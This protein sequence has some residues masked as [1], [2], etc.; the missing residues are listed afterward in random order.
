MEQDGKRWNKEYAKCIA[1]WLAWGNERKTSHQCAGNTPWKLLKIAHPNSISDYIPTITARSR[2]TIGQRNGRDGDQRP[3]WWSAKVSSRRPARKWRG[4]GRKFSWGYV[5][6]WFV[7]TIKQIEL[8][9]LLTVITYI[10][11]IL[12]HTYINTLHVLGLRWVSSSGCGEFWTWRSS[13]IHSLITWEGRVMQ[14]INS[15]FDL[16]SMLSIHLELHL[17]AFYI[18]DHPHHHQR[19]TSLP[20]NSRYFHFVQV[21]DAY[22]SGFTAWVGFR[23][24][25]MQD[26]LAFTESWWLLKVWG[27]WMYAKQAAM[28]DS[29]DLSNQVKTSFS[30][31]TR[32]PATRNLCSSMSGLFGSAIS[33]QC[34]TG[35]SLLAGRWRGVDPT[36]WEVVNPRVVDFQS[37]WGSLVCTLI[38]PIF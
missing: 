31:P 26:R 16:T 35:A 15:E 17:N 5:R 34:W 23:S 11:N 22:H 33:Y 36:N 20:L 37:K 25:E 28:L 2:R 13:C 6:I 21:T 1:P 7:W 4:L 24:E 3:Q 27:L 32:R 29:S 8:L 38:Q 10:H 14:E 9:C 18:D 30:G 19:P 12:T